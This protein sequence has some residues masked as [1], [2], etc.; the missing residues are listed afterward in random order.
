MSLK[1][2]ANNMAALS[3]FSRHRQLIS[4][5]LVGVFCAHL[6]SY[7]LDLRS[8]FGAETDIDPTRPPPS[9]LPPCG[10]D[11]A[12]IMRQDGLVCLKKCKP[13]VNDTLGGMGLDPNQRLNISMPV[14]ELCLSCSVLLTVNIILRYSHHFN[15]ELGVWS[16]AWFPHS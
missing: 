4:F 2:I 8:L 16:I 5:I 14:S 10:I 15:K 6:Y 3:I 9:E 13:S 7:R 12:Q 1:L 11:L